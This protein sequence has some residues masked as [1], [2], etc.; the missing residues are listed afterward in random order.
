MLIDVRTAENGAEV[1]ALASRWR[2]DALVIDA[3]LP[4]TTGHRL[5]PRRRALPG[6][7][8][9]PAFVCSADSAPEDVH[10]TAPSGFVAPFV[11]DGPKPL[12]AER[13]RAEVPACLG[14]APH[15]VLALADNARR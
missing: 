9:V 13:V 1:L 4:D 10:R 3:H 7:T 12:V 2:P 15:P 5:L 14:R 11:A 8:D 6:L